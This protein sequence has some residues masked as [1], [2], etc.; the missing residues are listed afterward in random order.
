M[1]LL[2]LDR[3]RGDRPRFRPAQRNRLARHLAIAIFAIVDPAQGRVDLGDELALPVARAQFD[4]PVGLA[5]R[6]IVEVRLADRAFLQLLQRI[7][8]RIQNGFFPRVKQTA[9][10]ILLPT[11]RRPPTQAQH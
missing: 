2:R 6:P 7:G 5:R 8:R 11:S 3:H 10:I 1:P 4:G 9:E